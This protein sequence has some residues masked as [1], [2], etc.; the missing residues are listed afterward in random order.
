MNRQV[1]TA[2]KRRFSDAAESTR[3]R[4]SDDERCSVVSCLRA[5]GGRWLTLLRVQQTPYDGAAAAAAAAQRTAA[6]ATLRIAAV[7]D[8]VAGSPIE[9][10]QICGF[11][12][13]FARARVFE[14]SARV[15]VP[16]PSCWPPDE[17]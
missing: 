1:G 16:L 17:W 10:R 5:L 14:A 6:V 13:G 7:H 3:F 8:V 12:F 4:S 2:G 11:G 15:R 9:L